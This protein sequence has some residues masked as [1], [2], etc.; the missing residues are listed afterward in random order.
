MRLVEQMTAFSTSSVGKSLLVTQQ[1]IAM[2]FS[3]IESLH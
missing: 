3:D 1:G 2:N